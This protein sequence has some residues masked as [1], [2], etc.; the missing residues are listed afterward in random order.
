MILQ[1]GRWIDWD[2]IILS[3][4]ILNLCNFVKV[5]FEVLLI[6]ILCLIIHKTVISE[7]TKLSTSLDL[8]GR[9]ESLTTREWRRITLLSEAL[10]TSYLA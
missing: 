4:C 7:A 5:S 8:V 3:H 10:D 2:Y 9:L 6:H 1:L